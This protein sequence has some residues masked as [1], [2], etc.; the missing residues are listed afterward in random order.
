M[1]GMSPTLVDGGISAWV[2]HDRNLEGLIPE[3]ISWMEAP[4]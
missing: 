1:N 3:V 4:K 2:I